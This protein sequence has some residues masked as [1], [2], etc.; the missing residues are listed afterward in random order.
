MITFD[1]ENRI[2]YLENEEMTYAFGIFSQNLTEHLWFGARTGPDLPFGQYMDCGGAHIVRLPVEDG[3]TVNPNQILLS[4]K[5]HTEA[6]R[7][8]SE[9]STMQYQQQFREIGMELSDNLDHEG[10]MQLYRKLVY[11]DL[12]LSNTADTY[13]HDIFASPRCQS[14]NC[15]PSLPQLPSRNT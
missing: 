9:K 3:S 10:W 5:K 7:L 13:I 6:R 8:V 15:P 2:F 4:V 12:E 14:T 1:A 11:W